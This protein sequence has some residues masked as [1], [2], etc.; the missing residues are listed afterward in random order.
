MKIECILSALPEPNES[1][2]KS[3][4]NGF[5]SALLNQSTKSITNPNMDELL[6]DTPADAKEL[7][8]ALLVLNPTR[9]LNA[10]Q[11][12]GHKYVEK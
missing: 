3:V 7:V 6:V 8:K 4:G 1:D 12:M 10:K 5:G 9:R 2:L 11:A